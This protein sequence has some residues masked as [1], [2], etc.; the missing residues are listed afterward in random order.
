VVLALRLDS[1]YKQDNYWLALIDYINLLEKQTAVFVIAQVPLHT[2]TNFLET[3]L[4]SDSFLRKGIIEEQPNTNFRKANSELLRRIT[5]LDKNVYVLNIE[6]LFCED[7]KCQLTDDQGYP[8][9]F[10]DDHLTAYGAEWAANKVL[11]E[12]Q[13][14]WFL[15]KLK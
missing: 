12:P 5:K 4:K 14:K 7:T 15:D 8:L 13:F 9:Y 11:T 2:D 6:T 1:N 10:D 3:Y